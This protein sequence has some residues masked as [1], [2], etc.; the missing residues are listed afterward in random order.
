MQNGKSLFRK[1]HHSLKTEKTESPCVGNSLSG[2]IFIRTGTVLKR[3]LHIQLAA[4]M[5][6]T[7]KAWEQPLRPQ[8][9]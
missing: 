3:C 8:T 6:T 4:V 9:D 5:L 2:D 7:A 1:Q